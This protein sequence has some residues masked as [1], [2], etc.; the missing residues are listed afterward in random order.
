MDEKFDQISRIVAS[1]MPRR[2]ALRLSFGLIVSSVAGS[3]LTL[4]KA[5][6]AAA[7][8]C[9]VPPDFPPNNCCSS[10][11]TCCHLP[12]LAISLCC[13]AGSF[14][15]TFA[16]APVPLCCQTGETCCFDG[17]CPAV[18]RCRD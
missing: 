16:S 7:Q 18:L 12:V 5:D 15:C 3:A 11:F 9:S 17:G 4:F 1:S 14:C 6:E 10:T 8:T 2:E 13:S